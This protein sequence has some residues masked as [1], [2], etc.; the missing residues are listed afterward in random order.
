MNRYKALAANTIILGLGQF[1]S[2]FLIILMMGFYQATLGTTGY[3]EINNIIDTATLLMSVAT[4][5]IGESIIRFGLDNAFDNRQV[6]S[7]GVRVTGIGLAVILLFVPLI[8]LFSSIFP[9]NAVFALL[10]DYAWITVAYVV[11]GSLKSCCALFVRSIG[12][13]KLYAVDGILTTVMNIIFNLILLLGFKMGNVGY[14][15]SVILADICSIAFLTIMAKL[16]RYVIFT[17]INRDMIKSM[18]SFCLP[19][20]PTAIMWW[21][22]NSSGSFF[23]SEFISFDA[24][25]IYKAAFKFPSMIS[26]F[27]GIFS[28]AWNMSAITENN[29]KTIASF[30][31]NV[32]NIF[33]SFVYVLAAGLMLVIRPAILIFCEPEFEIA[34]QYTPFLILSVSFTCFST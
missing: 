25:G 14:L 18:M 5:S 33:Q 11:T 10:S 8:G 22:I 4:L 7:I 23:V 34:Y 28:Q 3:G 16:W 15:L 31:T 21:I 6:F 9:D 24:S 2:K 1:G 29:S 32:F 27:S 12:H 17:G 26:I 13:V 20:I 30:Y 19:M